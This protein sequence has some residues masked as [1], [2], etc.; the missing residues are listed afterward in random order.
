MKAY[1][2]RDEALPR[3]RDLAWLL[4]YEKNDRFTIELSRKCDEW[5]LPPILSSLL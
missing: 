3:Q 5:T 1:A 4:Y 2:I